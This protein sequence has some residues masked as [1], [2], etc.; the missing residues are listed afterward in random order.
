MASIQC[1]HCRHE[2]SVPSLDPLLGKNVKCPSCNESFTVSSGSS[3]EIQAA[4]PAAMAPPNVHAPRRPTK[5]PS[6]L[7]PLE[8][9]PKAATSAGRYP[10][11]LRYI[12]IVEFLQ[13][14]FFWLAIAAGI[15]YGVFGVFMAVS[16]LISGE[17]ILAIGIL[18]LI[19]IGGAIYLGTV[20]LAYISAMAG[21]EF[22]RVFI[23]VENNTR[24]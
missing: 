8:Y 4:P 19:V 11:L 7:M 15:L 20:W 17:V 10:N 22:L 13:K 3:P 21:T 9:D 16:S 6:W 2:A 1:P 5:N 23:D 14:C 18:A 24:Q 12:K